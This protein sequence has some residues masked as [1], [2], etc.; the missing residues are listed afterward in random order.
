M[1]GPELAIDKMPAPVC[2]S[3]GVTSSSNFFLQ[4]IIIINYNDIKMKNYDDVMTVK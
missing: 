1:L 3:A 4:I 2:F